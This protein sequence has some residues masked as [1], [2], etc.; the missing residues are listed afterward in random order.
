MLVHLILG[1]TLILVAIVIY[2]INVTDKP[3]GSSEHSD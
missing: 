3:E 2:D 1:I